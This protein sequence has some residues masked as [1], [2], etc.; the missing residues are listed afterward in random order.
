MSEK[1]TLS[2]NLIEFFGK[3]TIDKVEIPSFIEE[4]INPSFAIRPY[5]IKALQFFLTYFN[6]PFDGKP[7]QNHQ[8]LFHMATGSG[9]T[10]LMAASILYLYKKG[11]RNF[12][13]FV[14]STNILQKTK[15]NFLNPSSIKYL[16]NQT[17]SIDGKKIS[18][19]EVNNFQST[20]ESSINIL[21]STIQNLYFSLDNPR[22][23]SLTI[24]DFNDK[25]L[26]LISDEAHHIN[27]DTRRGANLS[28]EELFE[29]RS[30]EGAVEK[31]FKANPNNV[32]LEFTATVDF[33]VEALADKYLPKLIFDYP[34]KEFR[35]DGYSKEVKVIQADLPPFERALQ[36]V[37]LSQ[38]RQ[39]IFESHKKQIKPVV[40]FKSKKIEDSKNFATEFSSRL[41]KLDVSDLENLKSKTSDLTLVKMFDY[42]EKNKI[43]FENL[44]S[45]LKE[46]F[47]D[48]K[49]ITV[50]SGEEIEDKQISLNTLEDINNQ[51]RAIFAVNMLNEGWD[52]LNLFDIVRLFDT[53][54]SRSNRVGS[55]TMS[56]AQLI[57]RGARYCPFLIEDSQSKFQRKYDLDSDNPLR[58][59]EEL[60]YHSSH[61][62]KYIQELTMALREIGIVAKSTVE[63]ELK[64]KDVFKQGML[65]KAGHIF[66]NTRIKYNREDIDGL[67]SSLIRQRHIIQL[68]SGISKTTAIFDEDT[69][70]SLSKDR[71]AKDYQLLEFD[72]RIIKKAI[73][74]IDFYNFDNLK[75][76]LPKLKSINEFI[77]S[78]K[79]LGK[80]G[81]EVN[82]L[83][84]EVENLST[85]QKLLITQEV[86]LNISSI[87]SS[88]KIEYKGSQEFYPHMIKSIFTDKKL[89]FSS[90]DSDD[91]QF[92]KSM[93]NVSEAST[94]YHLDLDQRDW[95]VYNDCY[96]TSEEK[97]LVKYIDKKYDDLKRKYSD[98]YLLRN[99]R[100]FQLYNFED[101][102]PLEPDFVLYLIGKE[103]KD[104]S[105]YQVFIEPKGG[106]LLKA[107][108]WKE[109]F[110]MELKEKSIVEQ[111]FQN[112]SYSVWGMPFFNSELRTEEFESAFDFLLD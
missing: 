36:A 20:N 101:G 41:K 88:D 11:Y 33:Q 72:I 85:E 18:V 82:G 45:E 43:T 23:N 5:Q 10:L 6:E 32:L 91:K 78:D 109:K 95:Y 79:Y 28:N 55:T 83:K 63:K 73:Q 108:E 75:K 98:V 54:D 42:F 74:K 111:L 26:V 70:E 2:Q 86:L 21:F 46:S 1:K 25:K 96:G 7:K 100:H 87:I 53:R 17:L 112:K 14:N 102:R 24:N 56:E 34:L 97:L 61:N 48:D 106:H 80:V 29:S 12:L 47:S 65:F 105:H 27:V 57:G 68:A 58:V 15:D 110:L 52:V 94:T 90:D 76:F 37:L 84:D 89:N 30:W 104:T 40:L 81:V 99:E 93:K 59:C 19:N 8:L 35:K 31:I 49:L 69:K 3:R 103:E 107:D 92:G 51:Y 64:V 44:I 4:N 50:N 9:K 62:P 67:D 77:T 22:E 60:Y 66:L 39:K 71:K 16:F 38:Y 13:F